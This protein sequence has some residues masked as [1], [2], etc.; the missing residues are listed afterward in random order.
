MGEPWITPNRCP[1]C[2]TSWYEGYEREVD[3]VKASDGETL[4]SSECRDEYER[5]GGPDEPK[6]KKPSLYSV[7]FSQMSWRA[8]NEGEPP[9]NPDAPSKPVTPP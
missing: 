3:P 8:V 5:L 2:L 4:C 9:A 7:P 6:P 1:V